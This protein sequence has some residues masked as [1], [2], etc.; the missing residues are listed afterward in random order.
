MT[1]TLMVSL[2]AFA[3]LYATLLWQQVHLERAADTLAR[4]RLQVEYERD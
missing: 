3:L 4:L 2:A 1:H